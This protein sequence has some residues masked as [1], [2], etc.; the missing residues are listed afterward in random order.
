[1]GVSTCCARC[2]ILGGSKKIGY[3]CLLTWARCLFGSAKPAGENLASISW[4]QY[5][6]CWQAKTSPL[7]HGIVINSA[8]TGAPCETPERHLSCWERIALLDRSHPVEIVPPAC[9]QLCV[10]DAVQANSVKAIGRVHTPTSGTFRTTTMMQ[11]RKEQTLLGISRLRSV[12][13]HTE[14]SRE[15]P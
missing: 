8:F 4:H 5:P 2:P 9:V 14:R 1:M 15:A 13:S 10:K 3:A 12:D 11:L 6:C 7:G